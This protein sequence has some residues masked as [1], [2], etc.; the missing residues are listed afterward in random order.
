[1]L[2][3][4]AYD[5]LKWIVIIFIPALATLIGA[6]GGYIN[7]VHT[8]LI[9]YVLIAVDTFFGTLIG[10]STVQYNSKK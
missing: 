2:S 10:V 6:I 8:D 3:N 4:K 9:V 1:M 5:I 7:W